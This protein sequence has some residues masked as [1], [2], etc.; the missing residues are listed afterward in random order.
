MLSLSSQRSLTG[1]PNPNIPESPV[2]SEPNESFGNIL[3]QFEQD[4]TVKRAEGAREATV[5]S[6]SA[7]SVVLDVGLKTEGVLPL[8]ELQ[9]HRASVNPGD[10]LAVTIKGRDPEG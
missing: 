6:V 1:M 4:H 2:V 9:K 10:R 7:D 5:V 3:S 8:L